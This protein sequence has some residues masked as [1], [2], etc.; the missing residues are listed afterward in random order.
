[1]RPIAAIATVPEQDAAELSWAPGSVAAAHEGY[2]TFPVAECYFDKHLPVVFG[3]L[4]QPAAVSSPSG[5]PAALR[6]PRP[7]P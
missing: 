6:A 3:A 2:V 4:Q 7:A 5:T 1:M